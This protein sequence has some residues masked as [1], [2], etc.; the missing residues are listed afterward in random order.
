MEPGPSSATDPTLVTHAPLGT[1]APALARGSAIGRYL[2]LEVI[3]RGGMGTVVLA[4]DPEL[5]RRIALKLVDARGNASGEILREAQTLARLSHP[6]VVTVHDAGRVG[7][8]IYIAMEYVGG[9]TLRRWRTAAP[10]DV[11]EILAVYLAAGRGLAAAHAAGVVHRDFKPDN[12]IVGD[13]GVVRV[14][15]F[16][17]A[18]TDAAPST[19]ERDDAGPHTGRHL[20]VQGTPAYMAPEQVLGRAVGPAADQYAFGVALLEALCGERPA[21]AMPAELAVGRGAALPPAASALPLRLRRI[22]GRMLAPAPHDRYPDMPTVLEALAASAPR[23]RRAR[24]RLGLAMLAIAGGGFAIARVTSAPPV[25]CSEAAASLESTW[26]PPQHEAVAQ[27]F[28]ALQTPWAETTRA[29]AT[30]RLDAWAQQWRE[31][32]EANCVAA[33]RDHSIDASEA[34]RRTDCL[35]GQRARVD[36]VVQLLADGGADVLERAVDSTVALPEPAQCSSAAA[37]GDVP[38]PDTAELAVEVA[39]VLRGLAQVEELSTAGRR[40]EA[41]ALMPALLAAANATDYAPLQARARRT[42]AFIE[43]DPAR[44]VDLAVDAL[45]AALA[46]GDRIGAAKSGLHVGHHLE[47]LGQLAEA[48][49]FAR[50]TRALVDAAQDPTVRVAFLVDTA[51]LAHRSGDHKSALLAARQAVELAATLWPP[52]DPRQ[53]APLQALASIS[54]LTGATPEGMDA[55]Q[56]AYEIAKS[57]YGEDHPRTIASDHAMTL[58]LV[59][60]GRLDEVILRLQAS[61]DRARAAHPGARST[62]NTQ[63]NLGIVLLDA[64]RADEAR[65]YLE[66]ATRRYAELDGEDSLSHGECLLVLSQVHSAQGDLAGARALAERGHAAMARHAPGTISEGLAYRTDGL[67]ALL[68]GRDDDARRDLLAA[69]AIMVPALGPNQ[70]RVLEANAALALAEVRLGLPAGAARQAWIDG[71]IETVSTP[72]GRARVEVYATAVRSVLAP[73]RE[74]ELHYALQQRLA[75]LGRTGESL[76]RLAARL[77]TAPRPR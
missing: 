52:D 71:R 11:D 46:I 31:T 49:H 23:R 64:G 7:E 35:E 44:G 19:D 17:L 21:P 69:L 8:Q 67:L 55:A 18:L 9:Q 75:P 4:D 72:M 56:R 65:A 47:D 25:Q 30:A 74:A 3:G 20:P 1:G 66:D 29:S 26:G 70:G 27:A 60:W 2:V 10:R 62:T 40:E 48:R 58:Q 57:A 39:R 6:N 36:A 14:L 16:G 32:S 73:E 54:T 53:L 13:D 50:V 15:D 12:A 38:P 41:G 63:W 51:D 42:L 61:Y 59:A 33:L 28:A 68:D 76:L 45:A 34:L 43:T 37:L 77:R 22:C 5:H 24:T